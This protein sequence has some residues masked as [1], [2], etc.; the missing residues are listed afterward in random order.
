MYCKNNIDEHSE[1]QKCCRYCEI[2][3]ER[4]CVF[5]RYNSACDFEVSIDE[6]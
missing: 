1:C 3:C 4:R 2:D 6:L 5:D